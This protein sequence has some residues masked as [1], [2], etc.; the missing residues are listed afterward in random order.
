MKPDFFDATSK[1]LARAVRVSTQ[2]NFTIH[3]IEEQH[4]ES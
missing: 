1:P 2:L 3:Q 4:G